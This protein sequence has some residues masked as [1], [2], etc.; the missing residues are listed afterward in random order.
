MSIDTRR[1]K[2]ILKR[3][4]NG[5]DEM[6]VIRSLNEVDLINGFPMVTMRDETDDLISCRWA[7]V[8]KPEGD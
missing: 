4:L 5:W 6:K 3:I 7:K 8:V 2:Y 1:Q